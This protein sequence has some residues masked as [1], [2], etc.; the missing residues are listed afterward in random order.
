MSV[1]SRSTRPKLRAVIHIGPIK[2]GSSAFTQQMVATQARGELPET[3]VYALTG[4]DT[5]EDGDT[6][7]VTR[8]SP[9]SLGPAIEWNRASGEPKKAQ[10]SAR[11]EVQKKLARRYLT[12][13]TAELREHATADTTVIFVEE[14][15]SRRP[16][17]GALL[18]EFLAVFDS[19]EFFCVARTQE[20]IVPSAINQR[21][22]MAAYPTA[23]DPSVERYLAVDNFRRQFDYS[24][25][26]TRWSADKRA[27]L[28]IV[29]F[30]ESDRGSQR[31]FYRI[32]DAIGVTVELGAP[33][34]GINVSMTAFDL[35]AV[36]AFKK[37]TGRWWTARRPLRK[38][39]VAIFK[40]YRAL[41]RQIARLVNS[42]R[43]TPSASDVALIRTS[44]TEAN[45]RLHRHLG[46]RAHS[47]E[48][49]EWFGD[50]G[51]DR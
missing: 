42:P 18:D 13:L 38:P 31:L 40:S 30:L 19:V 5:H 15:L 44:Y 43:V 50:K 32:L 25:I 22:K 33:V 49:R 23:W 47:P 9:W 7:I 46:K 26:V 35:A 6:G 45:E 34:E 17:P 48:W 21:I 27:P 11:G 20:H 2:T 24:D 28:H 12:E 10:P 14:T 16:G 41:V 39:G 8:Q 4:T 37:A 1:A 3:V 36:S 51:S 29:P